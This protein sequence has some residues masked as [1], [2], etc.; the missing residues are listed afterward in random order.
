[1]AQQIFVRARRPV[2]RLFESGDLARQRG[3]SWFASHVEAWK[4]V[5][6][7]LSGEPEMADAIAERSGV[8]L[9][10]IG[11]LLRWA[12]RHGFCRESFRT[13][14]RRHRCLYSRKP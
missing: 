12:A 5:E 9:A 1:M 4:L 10:R 6:P 11:G 14:G 13:M 7:F 8:S 3:L 2:I